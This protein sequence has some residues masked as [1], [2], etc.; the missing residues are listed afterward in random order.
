MGRAVGKSGLAW[1]Q[2]LPYLGF[3]LI[4]VG[5]YDWSSHGGVAGPSEGQFPDKAALRLLGAS[6]W[7]F[8]FPQP[9]FS[10]DVEAP[11]YTEPAQD[12]P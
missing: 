4:Y 11:D 10:S 7:E 5:S 9:F 2:G 12:G 3:L 6:S 8:C 1:D